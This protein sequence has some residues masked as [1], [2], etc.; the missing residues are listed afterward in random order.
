VA[1]RS[2]SF[3]DL[4]MLAEDIE[5]KNQENSTELMG[6]EQIR[7]KTPLFDPSKINIKELRA[8][9]KTSALPDAQRDERL[10]SSDSTP[11]PTSQK[12]STKEKVRQLLSR[13]G[14]DFNQKST[15]SVFSEWEKRLDKSKFDEKRSLELLK[16]YLICQRLNSEE[17]IEK[18]SAVGKK[19]KN[20]PAMDHF[21][22]AMAWL[23]QQR[24][25]F[26]IVCAIARIVDDIKLPVARKFVK[27]MQEA[28]AIP[29]DLPTIISQI[30]RDEL[31]FQQI[32]NLFREANLSS[33]LC[34]EVSYIYWEGE[35]K[36][37]KA[38]CLEKLH[39][40]NPQN[41][42]LEDSKIREF[43]KEQDPQF[44]NRPL[45]IRDRL[46]WLLQQDNVKCFSEFAIPI[47]EKIYS[48][49]VPDKFAKL[50]KMRRHNIYLYLR[51]HT[52]KTKE[53]RT[54]LSRVGLGEVL[55]L[56]ILNPWLL[57]VTD[58]PN[59]LSVMKTLTCLMQQLSNEIPFGV[60]K[61]ILEK[62]NPLFDRFIG[63]HRDFLDRYASIPQKKEIPS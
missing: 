6:V 34:R 31:K 1:F 21:E 40:I 51:D 57:N 46:V 44:V 30:T 41:C 56:R 11:L 5:G 36:D 47:I 50:L 20:S 61:P 60:E 33:Y 24:D 17:V 59:D 43:K 14:S 62:L 58:V 54:H 42:I 23:L 4:P 55:F 7:K 49:P 39:A 38:F 26:D 12:R 8:D 52:N 37:L 45:S 35:L 63:M 18:L 25:Y 2:P 22:T 29:D 28:G 3:S 19:L 32:E 48:L 16:T 13:S 15:D 9:W 27:R 53:E 10:S